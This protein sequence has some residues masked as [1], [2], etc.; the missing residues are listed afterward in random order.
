MAI[1]PVNIFYTVSRLDVRMNCY[2]GNF[3]KYFEQFAALLKYSSNVSD[4]LF[5]HIMHLF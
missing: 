4:L 5:G 1:Q 3:N 2:H